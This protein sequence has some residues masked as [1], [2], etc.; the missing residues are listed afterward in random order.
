MANVTEGTGWENGIYQFETTDAI[1]GGPEGIDNLP[2]K[3]LASRTK[4]LKLRADQVD[5]AKGNFPDIAS[6]MNAMD[7]ENEALGPDMQNMSAAVLKFALEQAA[8]ANRGVRA[9]RQQ[10]QQEGEFTILNKGVVSGCSATKSITAARNL[11]LSAG[12]CFANGRSYTVA[13]GVNAASVPS[14]TGASNVTVYAYLYQDAGQL[15]RLAVTPLGSAVPTNGIRVYSL[16]VPPNSTDATDP[17]LTNVTLT[18]VRRIEPGFPI[19]LDSPASVSPALETLN[20]NDY[21]ID[22]DVVSSVGAPCSEKNIVVSS[23]ATN[24]FTALLASAADSVVV[25]YRA[26]KLNQ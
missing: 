9:L 11:S 25:R 24:G 15:W 18:D 6:R 20:A 7:T 17:N 22:F 16:T 14:N 4:Y 3:Q 12:K 1:T 23:R 5:A 8:L 10:A 21:R 2:H 13:D 19:S 26:S